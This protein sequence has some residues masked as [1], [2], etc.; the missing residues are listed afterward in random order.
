MQENFHWKAPSGTLGRLTTAAGHRA[1]LLS[2]D[3]NALRQRALAQPVAPSFAAALRAGATVSVIAELKRRSPSKGTIN[4]GLVA[5]E[6][7]ALYAEAGARALSIL[8]E[9]D[10]FGGSTE[11]LRSVAQSVGVPLLKKDFHVA[12]S[13]VWEA[14]ANGAS[15]I[16]F[17]ARALAPDRLPILV[18]TAI[19]AGLEALVEIRTEEELARALETRAPVIGVNARDLETLE[20]EPWV[21]ERLIPMIPGDRVRVA[22]SGMS[23]AADVARAAK[24][25]ADAVLIGSSLSSSPDPR[26][27]LARLCAISRT[28]HAA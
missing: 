23:T 20:I 7:A 8:T 2:A 16:L 9:P 3:L 18:E 13:Q 14:R 26:G 6:R 19:A 28:G 21:S 12:E 10:E 15:A 27:T 22:E 11:D 25:G 4:A 24:L 1:T 5:A 17:I